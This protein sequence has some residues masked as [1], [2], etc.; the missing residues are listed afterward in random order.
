MIITFPLPTWKK[1]KKKRNLNKEGFLQTLV[2]ENL[3]EKADSIFDKK[4]RPT[5]AWSNNDKYNC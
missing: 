1:K 2:L 4:R 5:Y 3:A